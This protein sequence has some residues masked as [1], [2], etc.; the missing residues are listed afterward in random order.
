MRG[1]GRVR[2]VASTLRGRLAIRELEVSGLRLSLV[3][4]ADGKWNL[5]ES[6]AEAGTEPRWTSGPLAPRAHRR[7]RSDRV[8]PEDASAG[9]EAEATQLRFDWSGDLGRAR[10]LA[11]GEDARWRRLGPISTRPP[12]L[13]APRPWRPRPR[14]RE[15]GPRRSVRE[16]SRGR[17]SSL[18]KGRLAFAGGHRGRSRERRGCT[19][20]PRATRTWAASRERRG[21]A[22][23]PFARA[24][25]GPLADLALEIK[26]QADRSRRGRPA[27]RGKRHRLRTRGRAPGAW[28][29][30]AAWRTGAF[31]AS[32]QVPPTGEARAEARWNGLD[33]ARL[34]RPFSP[35]TS[36]AVR[37]RLAGALTAR[38]PSGAFDFARLTVEAHNEVAAGGEGPHPS[39]A[40][41]AKGVAAIHSL[42]ATGRATLRLREGRYVA[43]LDQ[44]F[45][46]VLSVEGRVE[47]RL[48]AKGVAGATLSG[49]MRITL[50]RPSELMRAAGI[51]LARPSDRSPR[52]VVGPGGHPCGAR[53]QRPGAGTGPRRLW[54]ALDR[55]RCHTSIGKTGGRS[56]RA[57]RP[58]A[59]ASP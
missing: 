52:G 18:R 29:A 30:K 47:G 19:R 38:W 11:A 55:R 53:G 8:A 2:F 40:P 48:P 24:P 9:F 35:R 34:L 39:E 12:R 16:T 57:S 26:A 58:A 22:D 59:P 25:P 49:P 31:T 7:A 10:R 33:V 27:A 46:D 15:P 44:A 41:P 23:W 50:A 54:R 37:G 21:G 36:N 17:R 45:S 3:R 13:K 1:V 32:A 4:S 56:W 6:A 42:A 51:S 20:R 14:A 43:E 5:P 28:K